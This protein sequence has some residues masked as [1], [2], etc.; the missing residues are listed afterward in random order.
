M[1]VR[2][3]EGERSDYFPPVE[4]NRRW[5]VVHVG[6][7][8]CVSGQPVCAHLESTAPDTRA[9]PALLTIERPL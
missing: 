7:V 4:K 5:A 1:P 9:L 3:G 6:Y 8:L 2:G